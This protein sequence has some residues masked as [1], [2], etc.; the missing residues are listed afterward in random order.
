[1]PSAVIRFAGC[2]VD[3]QNKKRQIKNTTILI[4]IGFLETYR[5][6][7]LNLKFLNKKSMQNS[8]EFLFSRLFNSNFYP[9]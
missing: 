3:P 4:F 5:M 9:I 6:D 7:N 1:M 2:N 8:W